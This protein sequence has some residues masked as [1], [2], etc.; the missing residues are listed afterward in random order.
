VTV[1][2]TREPTLTEKFI[3]RALIISLL[4]HFL[5]YFAYRV[6][7]SQGWWANLAMPRWL[8]SITEAMT[9]QIPKKLGAATP[10]PPPIPMTFVEVDPAN[11]L[12]EPPKA[13]K[14]YGARNTAAANPNIT[15]PSSVPDIR[16]KQ[17]KVLKTTDNGKPKAQPLQPT[18]PKQAAPSAQPKAVA[19]VSEQTPPA[20]PKPME[21]VSQPKK[22]YAPGDMA[23][24][25][26]SEMARNT[27]NDP[28]PETQATTAVEA[29][30][31]SPAQPQVQPVPD[32]P[33]TIADA[34][35]R[36]GTLGQPMR[37]AGGVPNIHISPGLDVAGSAL[38][39]Y[40][41]QMVA[42]I[43]AR[44][45]QL[46]DKHTPNA[47]GKVVIEFRLY[48]D[49]RVDSPRIKQTD[50]SDLM[51]TMCM[52]AITES[53]KYAKWP[54]EMRREMPTDYRDIQFTFFYDLE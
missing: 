43:K 8:Q 48:P 53:A 1:S 21:K 16:G 36:D 18:P 11:A 30:S 19:K 52:R 13:P 24:A 3:L 10:T 29:Q 41:A 28:K 54:P 26:P 38:G 33:R 20:Q 27:E 51:A 37:Q 46:W 35:A 2:D 7:Q 6:G 40:D 25:R 49:G 42:A 14:Y 31:E 45:D 32:R 4:I 44:W 15:K 39:D 34:I 9:P 23:M 12:R 47:A 5:G 17:D 22:E 50:V